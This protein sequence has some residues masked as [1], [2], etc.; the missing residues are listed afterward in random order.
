MVYATAL[1]ACPPYAHSS[2]LSS[3]SGSDQLQLLRDSYSTLFNRLNNDDVSQKVAQ[4]ASCLAPK[5]F[6][7]TLASVRSLVNESFQGEA[8]VQYSATPSSMTYASLMKH[9]AIAGPLDL[10]QKFL[11]WMEEVESTVLEGDLVKRRYEQQQTLVR[12]AVFAWT[13]ARLKV[14]VDSHLLYPTLNVSLFCGIQIERQ[15]LSDIV[16]QN[17]LSQRAFTAFLKVLDKSCEVVGS[18]IFQELGA[19]RRLRHQRSRSSSPMKKS[20]SK[21]PRKSE[22][23]VTTA[24]DHSQSPSKR[25]S[26]AQKENVGELTST[27]VESSQTIESTP[28]NRKR[29][30][31]SSPS[32][33][34][35]RK[36]R[37]RPNSNALPAVASS[38]RTTLD[39]AL[40]D[41]P[42]R[43]PRRS[44]V[45]FDDASLSTTMKKTPRRQRVFRPGEEDES[46][47][48]V[49]RD[50]DPKPAVTSRRFRPVFLDQRQWSSRDPGLEIIW[51]EAEALK[52]E[53]IKFH[54][55]PL[56][57]ELN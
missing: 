46:E 19:E 29:R 5:L 9:H 54:G 23:T 18:R 25:V 34:Q 10:R 27:L 22:K 47:L 44:H 17:N 48:E 33:P 8:A 7:S 30:L 13:C 56:A 31:A 52:K 12:C 45:E 40:P 32:E 24:I 50:E 6:K 14:L 39:D 15:S 28:P 53:M 57:Q 51:K 36:Q 37:L 16:L 11:D 3:Q 20:P 21:S 43:L 38:S 1:L 35:P 42:T 4:E 2:P 55:H 41:L 26:V 49:E